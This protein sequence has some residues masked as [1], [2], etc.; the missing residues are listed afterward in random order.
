MSN[1]DLLEMGEEGKPKIIALFAGKDGLESVVNDVKSEVDSFEHDL[2][3]AAGRK[4]TASLSAK[5]SRVKVRLDGIG[6]DLVSEW[7]KK[8]KTVDESRKKMREDL[9]A[10]RDEARKPLTEWEVEEEEKKKKALAEA[11]ERR[12][13]E[14]KEIDHE[15]AILLNEKFDRE[16]EEHE[17]RIAEESAARKA[18]EDRK[19]REYE[20]RIAKEAAASAE[21][22]KQAA[23]SALHAADMARRDAEDQKRRLKERIDEDNRI[24]AENMAIAK[25]QAKEDA[26]NAAKAARIAE[27]ERQEIEI[28]RVADEEAKREANRRH[29]GSVRKAAKEALITNCNLSEDQARS[30]VLAIKDNCIPNVAIKY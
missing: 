27:K 8:S 17:K 9:D 1:I 13:L 5:V 2:S 7:K 11:E 21:K 3:T 29:V 16:A 6:K 23:I 12:L 10:I 4:R 18:E 30:V 14:Q 25:K 28:K 22:E 15:I 20:E 26:E 19:Q 24:A